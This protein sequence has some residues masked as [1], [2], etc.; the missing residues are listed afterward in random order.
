M[1][2]QT[3]AIAAVVLLVLLMVMLTL[4]LGIAGRLDANSTPLIV[5]IFSTVATA[6]VALLSVVRTDRTVAELKKTNG[7]VTDLTRR[8]EVSDPGG[9]IKPQGDN[10]PGV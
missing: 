9:A 10:D 7:S 2:Y 4:G 6:V 5:T 1:T 8:M 3:S